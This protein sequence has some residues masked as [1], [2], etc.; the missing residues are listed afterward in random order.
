MRAI[1]RQVAM[2]AFGVVVALAGT[3]E[4]QQKF[5]IKYGWASSTGETDP[6]ALAAREFKR[7]LEAS[8][9]GRI[10]VQLFPNRQLGDE[11]PMLEG[12]R[13]GTVDMATITNATTATMES[14]FQVIDLPFLFRDE[15]QAHA[16][17][18]GPVGQKLAARAEAKG[19]KVLGYI[20]LGFRHMV[21]NVRPVTKPDDVRGVKYRVMQSPLYISMFSSLEGNAV[22]MSWGDMFPALQQGAIDG[23]EVP[24]AIIEQNK[25]FEMTKFLSLTNHTYTAA[26]LLISKRTFERLPPELA[27]AVVE[28][29]AAATKVQ[30]RAMADA[31]GKLI[32]SLQAK[33]MKVNTVAD[34]Q[35]FRSAMGTVYDQTRS[36]V[37]DALM[38]EILAAVG[39]R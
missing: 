15:A 7:L 9:N 38:K 32:A 17:L 35:P 5:T 19:V 33:G 13:F 36:S 27:K 4:A 12:M 28:A 30:R 24:L 25:I 29:G 39:S 14:A 21:N 26:E 11:K 8:S 20:E 10:E 2:L 6:H 31:S 16:V 34:V 18:D 37:G 1:Y 22:P 23:L 3:A